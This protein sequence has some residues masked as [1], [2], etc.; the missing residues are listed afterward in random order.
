[1]R[2]TVFTL[3]PEYFAGPLDTS[4][5]GKARQ[6]G[7]LDVRLVDFRAYATDRH[8]TVDDVPYGGGPGMVLKPE[9]IVAAF[10]AHPSATLARRIYLTPWG[11][12]FCHDDARRLAGYDEL[13][14]LCGRYEG[15]DERVIDGWIDEPISLGDYVLS[16]GEA[17]ACCL[18]EAVSRFV[19]GV[20]GSEE[21]L[22]EES[23]TGGL[24]EGPQYTRPAEFRGQA[25]PEVLLS[26]HHAR[27]EAWRREQALARTRRWRPDLLGK[28]ASS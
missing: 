6:A 27:I 10:E 17:A 15:V 7:L 3:F 11:R 21:S 22:S 9:P 4:L 24:L 16:G 1:M 12:P 2:L 19:P 8:R 13:Q 28:G 20:L 5:L 26:G 23:F 18:I 25:V 14:I